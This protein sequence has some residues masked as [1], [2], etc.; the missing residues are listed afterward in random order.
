MSP[1]TGSFLNKIIPCRYILAVLGSIALAIVYGLKVNLSVAIV[2]MVK[3]T[4][5]PI[6]L[7]MLQYLHRRMDHLHG[8]AA[9]KA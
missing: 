2:G 4:E 1:A 6:V 3:H 7:G 5:A 8:Q 9:Y